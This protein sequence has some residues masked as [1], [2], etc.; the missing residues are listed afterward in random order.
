MKRKTIVVEIDEQ[1]NS[2]LDLQGFEGK[3]CAEAAK[4]FRGDDSVKVERN[5]REF[6]VQAQAVKPRQQKA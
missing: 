6:Y 2:S 3:G 5:K 1:G 4:D